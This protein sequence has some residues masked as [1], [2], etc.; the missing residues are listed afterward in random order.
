MVLNDSDYRPESSFASH[1]SHNAIIWKFSLQS[2]PE[3]DSKKAV[4]TIT[5]AP[6]SKIRP[7][8]MVVEGDNTMQVS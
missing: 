2:T 8:S 5:M 6:T 7:G 4:V 1:R 3:K